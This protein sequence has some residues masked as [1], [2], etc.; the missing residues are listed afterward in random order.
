MEPVSFFE[1][2]QLLFERCLTTV[3]TAFYRLR[4][5]CLTKSLKKFR[6]ATFS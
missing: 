1:G 4:K 5:A 6:K 2:M 3:R